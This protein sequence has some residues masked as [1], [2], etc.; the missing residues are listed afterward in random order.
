MLK[1]VDEPMA[2]AICNFFNL[3]DPETAYD[4]ACVREKSDE[5]NEGGNVIFCMG[6][7][8]AQDNDTIKKIWDNYVVHQTE[9]T[10]DGIC[11]ATGEKNGDSKNSSWNKR[12]SRSTD[13]WSCF[14]F[15]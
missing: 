13:K 12:C 10:N 14:G 3:W 6:N 7:D 5:L 2:N 8:F 9:N 15:V 1:N 4:N 11:L